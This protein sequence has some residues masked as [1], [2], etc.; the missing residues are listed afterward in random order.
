[1]GGRGEEAAREE[2]KEG[3]PT[4]GKEEGGKI[5]SFVRRRRRRRRRRRK[6]CST[7][8]HEEGRIFPPPLEKARGGGETG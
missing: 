1:M 7:E 8:E 2:K 3:F 5:W 6:G 4:A